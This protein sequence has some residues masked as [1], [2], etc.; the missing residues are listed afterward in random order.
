MTQSIPSVG[1]LSAEWFTA[2]LRDHGALDAATSVASVSLTPFGSAESMMSALFRATLSYD[3][4]TDAPTSLIVKLASE[5]ERQRFIAGLFKFYER[6]IRF[7][8][9]LAAEARVRVPRSYLARM[10]P[11]EPYFVLVLEEVTGADRSTSSTASAWTTPARW[12]ARSP[13]STRRSGAGTS[14]T[15]R[16][17]SSR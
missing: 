7:Y 5:S 15:W 3:G 9:E 16:R 12:C 2:M 13:I 4:A 8:G 17:R 1:D 6:E 10:H 14:A 11:S